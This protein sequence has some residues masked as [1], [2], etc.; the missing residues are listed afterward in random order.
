[1]RFFAVL[2]IALAWPTAAHASDGR[3][4]LTPTGD[5]VLWISQ[6][7]YVRMQAPGHPEWR[8]CPPNEACRPIGGTE[9]WVE[10]GETAPGTVFESDFIDATGTKTERSPAWQGRV[11]LVAPPGI[12]GDLRVGGSARPTPAS[13]SG[14]WG[15]ELGTPLVY[16]CPGIGRT[17]CELLAGSGG[18]SVYGTGERALLDRHAGWYVYAIEYRSARDRDPMGPLAS[19]LPPGPAPLPAASALLAVSEPAG[20][21]AAPQTI[22]EQG[23]IVTLRR[24]AVRRGARVT[25]A[26][27]F[28]AARCAV[29]LS[30]SDGRRTLRRTLHVRGSVPLS[31]LHGK[32]LR[33]SLLRV[34]VSVDGRQVAAGRVRL[35]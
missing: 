20:P 30:V 22:A 11:A 12:A 15:D 5:P 9:N 18:F 8:I 6:I 2:L 24:S 21:V 16:A 31:I 10:P 4:Q 13:W 32:R 25:V 17:N 29:K 26:R 35:R 3:W 1:M 23:P 19:P 7:H 33:P 34:R 27:L 14:G 28:C